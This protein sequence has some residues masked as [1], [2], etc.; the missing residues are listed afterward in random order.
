MDI[1][2]TPLGDRAL[3]VAYP[4]QVDPAI[5]AAVNAATAAIEAA[6]LPGILDVVPAFCTVAIHYRPEVIAAAMAAG[7]DGER[8]GDRD[9]SP[10]DWLARR[11]RPLLSGT[12]GARARGHVVDVPVVYGGPFG[13]DLAEV[14]ERCR[15]TEDEVIARH[16]ASE[17][18]VYM[19]GFTP[20]LP[21]IGGLDPALELPRRATP[22]TRVPAGTVAIAREQTVI[23][24]CD[25]PGG[26][27]LIGRTPLT[28]F[29]ARFDPPC[30]ILPGD[31][32][33]FRP[34]PASAWPS[35]VAEASGAWETADATGE[36]GGGGRR[37]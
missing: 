12:V 34:M 30:R 6:G 1:R 26:W 16:V 25:S 33:R 17:H 19:L 20:G 28:L 3:I 36:P 37:S 8:V 22:R 13:P 10:F 18:C 14:A 24:S 29:D 32:L 5:N 9:D 4:A 21:F 15:L 7:G 2:I 35:L 11:L 23:Y 27:N 31:R